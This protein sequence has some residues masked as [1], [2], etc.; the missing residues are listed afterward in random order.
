MAKTYSMNLRERV[1]RRMQVCSWKVF[2]EMSN[3]RL[4][5][6]VI[7]EILADSDFASTSLTGTMD[8]VPYIRPR[9]CQTFRNSK[10]VLL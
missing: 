10:S 4:G 5:C 7:A 2:S 3:A 1:S 6:E 8:V 9:V